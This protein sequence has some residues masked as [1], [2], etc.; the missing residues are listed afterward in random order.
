MIDH[1][2]PKMLYK[3]DATGRTPLQINGPRQQ[4][5]EANF[6]IATVLDRKQEDDTKGDGYFNTHIEANDAYV[7]AIN[8]PD[9]KSAGKAVATVGKDGKKWG[10]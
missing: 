5:M 7:A 3:R 9:D 10:A 2:Y 6:E 4:Y 8:A 1:E